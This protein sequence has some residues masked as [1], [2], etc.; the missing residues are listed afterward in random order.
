[1]AHPAM[2][3]MSGLMAGLNRS[4]F[5]PIYLGP[6]K[7]DNS[8]TAQS[9]QERGSKAIFYDENDTRAAIE[10]ISAQKLDIVLSAPSQPAVFYPV[11]AKLAPLH[12]VVLEPNWTDGFPTSDYYISWRAAEPPRPEKFYR[13]KVAYLDHPPYWIDNR[14]DFDIKLTER[15]RQ[16]ILTKLTGKKP[17]DR[18]Y[19]C[20]STPPKLHGLMDEIILGILKKDPAAIVTFLR[21]DFPPAS[22]LHIRWREKFGKRYERIRFL[23]TLDR[24]EAHLLLHAVDCNLDSYPIGG[25]SSSFDGAILGIPTITWPADIPFGRWLA[26][27]YEYIG[28]S[29]LTA[30]SRDCYVDMAIRLATDKSW[31]RKKSMEIKSKSKILVE[32]PKAIECLQAFLLAAWKRHSSG[33]SNANWMSN[34]WSQ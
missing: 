26:S 30:D 15:K 34:A 32:N 6:G 11:M 10:T 21:N 13:S 8:Y 24:K 17:G 7:P 3:M 16:A 5:E 28:V 27:I 4:R 9:W 33:L 23:P 31:H 1:M 2:P 25:M 12:M 22:N 29:D 20:P 19:L 14:Y 18:V